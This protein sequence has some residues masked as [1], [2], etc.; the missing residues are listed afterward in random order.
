MMSKVLT[1]L[2]LKTFVQSVQNDEDFKSASVSDMWLKYCKGIDR[3]SVCGTTVLARLERKDSEPLVACAVS[4][5]SAIY[6][7]RCAAT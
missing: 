5:L 2:Q 3:K 1:S 4:L 6:L 7:H